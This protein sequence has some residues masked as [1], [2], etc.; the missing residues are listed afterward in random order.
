MA[1]SMA[2]QGGLQTLKTSSEN[3]TSMLSRPLFIASLGNPGRTYQNTR[4]NAGH[5]LLVTLASHLSYPPFAISTQHARGQISQKRDSLL[6]QCPTYM[7]V[8]GKAVATAWKAFLRDL[9]IDEQKNARLVVVH[10]ELESLPGKIKVKTGGSV[11]GHKGLLDCKKYL[12]GTEFWRMSVG[13]GRPESRDR[14]AV[15]SYVLKAMTRQEKDAIT[16]GVDEAAIQL[17][18]IA[19]D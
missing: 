15:T 6:W 19:E 18:K 17:D 11:K 1:S 10:D 13:I 5:I 7:N 4:H 14:D 16:S 8:S 2:W 3:P 12:N 9:E